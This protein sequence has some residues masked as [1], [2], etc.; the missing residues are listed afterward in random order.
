MT[1]QK[2]RYTKTHEWVN[3]EKN[4]AGESIATV[5][6]TDWAVKALTD[7]VF[8]ELPPAGREVLRR[9]AVW[10]GR[11]GQGGQRPLQPR[12][13]HRDRSQHAADR[14]PRHAQRRPVRG[15]L[16]HQGEAGRRP[17]R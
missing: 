5:G 3:V 15:R 13:R 7:L 6:I 2:L 11:V 12:R 16:A 1:P 17:A 14:P 10:R 8:L 4:A 9:R